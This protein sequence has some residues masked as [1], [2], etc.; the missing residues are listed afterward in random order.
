M[1]AFLETTKRYGGHIIVTAILM[2]ISGLVVLQLMAAAVEGFP[3]ITKDPPEPPVYNGDHPRSDDTGCTTIGGLSICPRRDEPNAHTGA[4]PQATDM[5][6]KPAKVEMKAG[7]VSKGKGLASIAY[8]EKRREAPIEVVEAVRLVAHVLQAEVSIDVYVARFKNG[9]AAYARPLLLSNKYELVFSEKYVPIGG[10][11]QI[12]WP[13]LGLVAHEVSHT[14]YDEGFGEDRMSNEAS[15]EY[16]AGVAIYRIGG[17]LEDSFE[18]S[19]YFTGTSPVHAKPGISA[20][21]SRAG[22]YEAKALHEG[23]AGICTPRIIGDSFQYKDKTCKYVLSCQ[24]KKRPIKVACEHS[25][26]AWN[27]Q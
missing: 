15:A 12:S 17:N 11:E 25:N 1:M 22:W 5:I 18:F 14:I 13:F 23:T 26:G 7:R 27:W 21:L 19:G 9:P 8:G 2:F 10:S 24:R 3:K 20:L 4:S 6:L 16:Q